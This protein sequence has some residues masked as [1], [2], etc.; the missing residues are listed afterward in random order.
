M[1]TCP[2]DMSSKEYKSAAIMEN[3]VKAKLK[4][5]NKNLILLGQSRFQR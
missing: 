3:H 1:K 5:K 4:K 2:S